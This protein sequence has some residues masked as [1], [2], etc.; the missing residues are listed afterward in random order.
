MIDFVHSKVGYYNLLTFFSLVRGNVF[1]LL[2][3]SPEKAGFLEWKQKCC[4]SRGI[5]ACLEAKLLFFRLT[6]VYPFYFRSLMTPQTTHTQQG[7]LQVSGK[8]GAGE[9]LVRDCGLV[10]PGEYPGFQVIWGVLKHFMVFCVIFFASLGEGGG[11]CRV[12]PPWIR[13]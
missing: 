11:W 13:H 1:P 5:W 10:F 8:G 12:R 4:L 7:R 6:A 3:F 2:Y 9:G